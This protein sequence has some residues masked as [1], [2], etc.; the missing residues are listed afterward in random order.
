MITDRDRS[1]TG[2]SQRGIV[3]TKDRLGQ[4]QGLHTNR[5]VQE[6]CEGG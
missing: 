4:I 3:M 2:L 6:V 5:E 1:R